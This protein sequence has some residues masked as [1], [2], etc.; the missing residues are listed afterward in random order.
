MF[1]PSDVFGSDPFASFAKNDDFAVTTPT[2]SETDPFSPIKKDP[3]SSLMN[4]ALQSNGFLS[5]EVSKFSNATPGQGFDPF[6]MESSAA[7]ADLFSNSDSFLQTANQSDG[8]QF[9]QAVSK[10]LGGPATFG[11]SFVGPLATQNQTIPTALS[12]VFSDPFGVQ[13]S[14]QKGW[15]G[16]GEAAKHV[17]PQENSMGLD[18]FASGSSRFG[19]SQKLEVSADDRFAALRMLDDESSSGSM[20]LTSPTAL[21]T[22]TVSSQFSDPF[23]VFGSPAVTQSKTQN[24]TAVGNS[25]TPSNT[26]STTADLFAI[27]SNVPTDKSSKSQAVDP[28]TN[29]ATKFSSGLTLSDPFQ[30]ESSKSAADP[31]Q[32]EKANDPF[33]NKGTGTFEIGLVSGI[34]PL[35][36]A[37]SFMPATTSTTSKDLFETFQSSNTSSSPGAVD[38]FAAFNPQSTMSTVSAPTIPVNSLQQPPLGTQMNTSVGPFGSSATGDLFSNVSIPGLGIVDSKHDPFLP[39][40]T[41]QHPTT[42]D[43]Q[44]TFTDP[45]SSFTAPK[46]QSN[47]G[48][49]GSKSTGAI[50]TQAAVSSTNPFLASNASG[51]P[52]SSFNPFADHPSFRMA[53]EQ[54]QKK[55]A[56]SVRFL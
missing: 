36:A 45:F 23:E 22:S 20:F 50:T 27:L 5:S 18:P 56:A 32:P 24:S 2:L 31:F 42:S 3:P 41:S 40:G 8:S 37:T 6:K 51:G 17:A 7:S 21:G 54:E 29:V 49:S 26:T 55:Q 47:F 19:N 35:T 25:V 53:G 44:S 13:Q 48:L 33:H 12:P 39:L 46:S 52:V 28:F 1:P 9:Q 15:S 34:A 10:P 30:T 14:T 11:D 43:F 4:S 16:G 38:H